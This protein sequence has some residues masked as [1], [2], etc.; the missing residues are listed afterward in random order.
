MESLFIKDNLNKENELKSLLSNSEPLSIPS[1]SLD[2][3]FIF[4]GDIDKHKCCNMDFLE[5]I[6]LNA[7][8]KAR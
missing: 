8:K 7:D 5:K 3:L 2:Y 6:L 4:L 1:N